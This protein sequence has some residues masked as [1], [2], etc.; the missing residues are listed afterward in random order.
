MK[1]NKNDFLKKIKVYI[2]QKLFYIIDILSKNKNDS[3]KLFWF[4]NTQNFG[5]SLNPI[6][7]NTITGEKVEWVKS[8]SPKEHYITIGS[9]LG[10][11]TKDTIVWGSGF[12]SENK[13]C[14][15]KPKKVCAVRGPKSRE[16]LIKDGIECPEIYGDPALLVPKIYSPSINKKYKLGIIP[17]FIDK[18]NEWL[19]NI[20]QDDEIKIIDIQN[21]NIFTFIDEVLSCEKI[22]SSSL[23]GIIVADAY[24][25]PSLWVEF[26]D[27]VIGNG[28]KF[29]D[30]FLSV[31]R[32]DTKPLIIN[33]ET[34]IRNI[35]ECFYDYK[36]DIDL[37]KLLDAAPFGIKKD[38]RSK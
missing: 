12:I 37:D 15:E 16:I 34:S 2:Y 28:F 33:K 27:K 38:Y 24:N 4:K 18:D 32:K 30:Y 31:K 20:K 21:P 5:D 22:A 8:Y 1:K 17:H 14:F 35:N 3:L 7:I 19:K 25:I 11:A 13:H 36:I 23:H 10:S 6:L 26:S 29:L 9:I